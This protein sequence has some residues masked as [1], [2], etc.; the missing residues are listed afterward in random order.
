MIAEQ[1]KKARKEKRIK[2][3]DLAKALNVSRKA[4]SFYETNR[5]I[6][7][8]SVLIKITNFFDLTIDEFILGENQKANFKDKKLFNFFKAA[9]KLNEIDRMTIKKVLEAILIKNKNNPK[10]EEFKNNKSFK[11]IFLQ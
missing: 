3:S 2:Q 4:I 9:D 11:D 7:P 1:L 8:L 10:L 6:P 5:A